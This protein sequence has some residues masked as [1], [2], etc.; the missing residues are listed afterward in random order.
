MVGGMV[1]PCMLDSMIQ[2]VSRLVTEVS[3]E[4]FWKVFWNVFWE[5]FQEMF[6]TLCCKM[7][8]SISWF[9]WFETCS[10]NRKVHKW[11]AFRYHN[12][13]MHGW[14]MQ[15]SYVRMTSIGRLASQIRHWIYFCTRLSTLDRGKKINER[16]A[17]GRNPCFSLLVSLNVEMM[18][19]ISRVL[20]SFSNPP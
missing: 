15:L 17:T 11:S 6:W 4:T 10:L 2:G 12:W 8:P 16:R 1:G 5:M 20:S 13:A 7:C 3:W 18:Y 19:R 14:Q 9:V